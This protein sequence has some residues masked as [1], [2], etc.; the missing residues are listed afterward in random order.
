MYF[1]I[2]Y[3]NFGFPNYTN[4]LKIGREGKPNMT[5]K[6]KGRALAWC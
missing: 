1:I 5:Y 2:Y 6:S 4:A 3:N